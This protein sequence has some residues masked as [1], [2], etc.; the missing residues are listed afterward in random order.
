MPF[1]LNTIKIIPQQKIWVAAWLILLQDSGVEGCVLIV[2][3]QNSKIRTHCWT[4]IDR[5][6]LN[7]PKQDT[8]R[9]KAK[10]K[11]QKTVGGAK[12]SL[13]SNPIPARDAQRAQTNLVCTRRPHR[14]WARPA[15]EGLGEFNSDDHYIH[16]CRQES[17]RRNGVAFIVN[18]TVQ[19][20]VL[21]Y[22]FKNDRMISLWVQGKPFS[23]T[24]IQVYAPTSNAEEAE[25]EWF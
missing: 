6:M 12:L 17:L 19:N 25:V 16:Y 22:K 1:N 13:E 23:I 9:P 20:A 4:A 21:G 2:S 5:R 15:F 8:P 7:P 18:K 24:V 10:K 14:D 11:P 3:R